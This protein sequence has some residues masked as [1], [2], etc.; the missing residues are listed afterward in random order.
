MEVASTHNLNARLVR[1]AQIEHKK[2][3]EDR[4]FRGTKLKEHSIEQTSFDFLL[5]LYLDPKK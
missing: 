2:F 5:D 3:L 1:R 4:L